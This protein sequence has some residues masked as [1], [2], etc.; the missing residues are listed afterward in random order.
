MWQYC[1]PLGY[2]SSRGDISEK[3]VF[4][5]RKQYF[6]MVLKTVLNMDIEDLLPL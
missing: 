5:S 1:A 3:I 2:L 6:H 4:F